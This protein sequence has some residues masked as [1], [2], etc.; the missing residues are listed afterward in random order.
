MAPFVLFGCQVWVWSYQMAQM[1]R[2][3]W[4]F[5]FWGGSVQYSARFQNTS[6]QLLSPPK[7]SPDHCK[8]SRKKKS[9]SSVKRK[10]SA[11]RGESQKMRK[12]S[13]TEMLCSGLLEAAVEK[14]EWD[15]G[16]GF[17]LTKFDLVEALGLP[18]NDD[19]D[20]FDLF[21]GGVTG[22]AALES[23]T[24]QRFARSFGYS[25][26]VSLGNSSWCSNP[27]P[28]MIFIPE[29]WFVRSG[30]WQLQAYLLLEFLADIMLWSGAQVSSQ[31]MFWHA[32][33]TEC[34]VLGP[35]VTLWLRTWHWEYQ[36]SEMLELI[37]WLLAGSASSLPVPW[38]GQVFFRAGC[39]ATAALAE[40]KL[41]SSTHVWSSSTMIDLPTFTFNA[42]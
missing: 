5:A 34:W 4:D 37:H 12:L 26:S 2:V 27:S 15:R 32:L 38:W 40:E 19:W 16:D 36:A 14:S 9:L 30:H 18:I 35:S 28:R 11:W 22:K 31:L 25:I 13:A 24:L 23:E 39:E 7:A 3:I 8:D 33:R 29:F 1:L 21:F 17:C 41:Q 6:A 20:A 42:A 10:M